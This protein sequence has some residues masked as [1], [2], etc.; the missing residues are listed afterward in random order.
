[1][2][3]L[4]TWARSHVLKDKIMGFKK[5]RILE[6]IYKDESPQ[7]VIMKS[8]QIGISELCVNTAL[9]FC[10]TYGGNVLYVMPTQGQMNDFSQARVLPR[11]GYD[12]PKKHVAKMGLQKVGRGYFYMRGSDSRNQIITVDAD[13]LIRDELDW[14]T[15]EHIPMMEE[16]LGASEFK[17]KRDVSTPTYPDFG[18]DKAFSASDQH[19][20]LIKCPHCNKHQELDF[21]ENLKGGKVVCVKCGRE[22][23]RTMVG[24]WVPGYP[25]RNL[26]GYKVNRLYSPLTTV[27]NLI[28]ASEKTSESEIQTFYNFTLGISRSPK[29]GKVGRDLILACRDMEYL[30]PEVHKGITTMGVDVGAVLNVRISQHTPQGR[31]AVYIGIV[32][33]FGELRGLMK[34]FHVGL[35]CI[36]ALPETRKAKEF[37]KA[38]EGKVK[39]VYF[40]SQEELVKLKKSDDGYAEVHCART[41]LLDEVMAEFA[42]GRNILPR[43]VEEIED[44]IKQITANVRVISQDNQGRDKVKWIA[45]SPDHYLFAEAYDVL[46]AQVKNKHKVLPTMLT[47]VEN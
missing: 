33:T 21:W 30:M 28:T 41:Q 32:K 19:R 43:N 46:A 29:G 38:F 34:Q 13:L 45:S 36:D 47:V 4:Y 16:R 27:E 31:R 1:M 7:I 42:E 35:C 24:E 18:I 44:Y 17:W 6:R 20:Y 5:Y 8:A 3:S 23:D 10:E 39:L 14:M 26:R 40:S 11:L 12:E 25:S 2:L 15:T 22:L 37:A 9:W